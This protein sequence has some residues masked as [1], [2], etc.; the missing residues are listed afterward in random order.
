MEG[1]WGKSNYSLCFQTE[2]NAY[3]MTIH[4][5]QVLSSSSKIPL[6]P[7]AK[8]PAQVSSLSFL[9]QE[10]LPSATMKFSVTKVV[11]VALALVVASAQA[12]CYFECTRQGNDASYCENQ[13]MDNNCVRM[14]QK[15]GESYSYCRRQCLDRA[16]ERPEA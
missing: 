11:F 9:P 15:M 3:I 10:T 16:P 13:C 4:L 1:A 12:G 7:L 8:Q 14:C 2:K 5:L 6:L